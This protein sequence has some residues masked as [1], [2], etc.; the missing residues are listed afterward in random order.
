MPLH[1]E[2]FNALKGGLVPLG[3]TVRI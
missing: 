3:G 1:H 2:V